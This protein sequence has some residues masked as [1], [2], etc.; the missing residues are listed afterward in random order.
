MRPAVPAV[1]APEERLPDVLVAVDGRDAEIVPL[2]AVEVE[3]DRAEAQHFG[4]RPR[5][6]RKDGRE[7][8]LRPHELGDSHQCADARELVPG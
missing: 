2:A 6:Q 4:N 5:D 8:A 1:G 7:I 3:H